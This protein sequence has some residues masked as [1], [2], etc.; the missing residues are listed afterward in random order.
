MNLNQR[1]YT[2]VKLCFTQNVAVPKRTQEWALSLAFRLIKRGWIARSVP[3]LKGYNL[4]LL[5]QLFN[6]VR[7]NWSV[8]STLAMTEVNRTLLLPLLSKCRQ[9]LEDRSKAERV[10][11]TMSGSTAV[12]P[13][14]TGSEGSSSSSFRETYDSAYFYILFVMVFYS[15]LAMALFKCVGSDEDKKDPYEE[16]LNTGPPS[17]QK[18]DGGRIAE[19][20]YF[21][22]ESGL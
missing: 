11:A 14:S 2:R 13:S 10:N 20:F 21:E 17:A 6:C 18:V 4:L 16:F 3:F 5:S 22:E 19:K 8:S 15:F 7:L 12:P 1:F 9:I